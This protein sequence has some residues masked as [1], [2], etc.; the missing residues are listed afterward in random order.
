MGF[1]RCSVPVSGT[2]TW[3]RSTSVINVVKVRRASQMHTVGDI[4]KCGVFTLTPARTTRV[5]IFLVN[6][7]ILTRLAIRTGGVCRDNIEF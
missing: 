1:S 6:I 3:L 2:V 5:S 7:P 4:E